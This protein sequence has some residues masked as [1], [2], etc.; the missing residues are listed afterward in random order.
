MDFILNALHS[1]GFNWHIALANFINFL[2]VLFVLNK[3]VFKRVVTIL[4]ERELIIKNG[5]TNASDSEKLMS[6][7]VLQSETLINESKLLAKK[8]VEDS[9]NIAKEKAS[10]IKLEAESEIMGLRNELQAQIKN[11]E[12]RLG[13]EFEKNAPILASKLISRI[14]TENMNEDS[15]NKIS[16]SL[17]K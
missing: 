3:F 11:V 6:E 15:N 5:L 1:I 13:E 17:T 4:N 9:I 16:F 2:L 14:L 7:A 8:N 10:K 12:V